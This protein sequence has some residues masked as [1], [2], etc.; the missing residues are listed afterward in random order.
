MLKT[1]RQK[2]SVSFASR[3]SAHRLFARQLIL[4]T[5]YQTIISLRSIK[6]KVFAD[7][8]LNVDQMAISVFDRVESFVFKNALRHGPYKAGFRGNRVEKKV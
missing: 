3:I 7:D 2:L 6:S 4:S 1:E 8:K 5:L